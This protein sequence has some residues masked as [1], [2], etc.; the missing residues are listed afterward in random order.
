MKKLLLLLLTVAVC[1]SCYSEKKLLRSYYEDGNIIQNGSLVAVD[2]AYPDTC[3]GNKTRLSKTLLQGMLFDVQFLDSISL[4]H[5]V[6]KD[7]R[8]GQISVQLM[9]G[10]SLYK[11][12]KLT[13][14]KKNG[15]LSI[16]RN[17]Y[18]LPIPFLYIQ[19]ERKLI[20]FTDNEGSLVTILGTGEFAFILFMAGGNDHI[21][22]NIYNKFL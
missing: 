21:D 17:L 3:S 12:F 11:E 8:K 1:T 16:K 18:L 6:L 22:V 20:L 4:S 2:G 10:D 19:H 15:Y 9:Q 7:D 14:Y 13:A 5:V